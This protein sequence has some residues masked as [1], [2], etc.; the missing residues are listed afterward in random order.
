M[1][2]TTQYGWFVHMGT[3]RLGIGGR[4]KEHSIDEDICLFVEKTGDHITSRA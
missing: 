4:K 2:F 3:R 1:G